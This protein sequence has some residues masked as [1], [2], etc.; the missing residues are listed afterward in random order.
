M[1]PEGALSVNQDLVKLDHFI[2]AR[3]RLSSPVSE[4]ACAEIVINRNEAFGRQSCV[5]TLQ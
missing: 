1:D 5:G 3:Y 4:V 2:C